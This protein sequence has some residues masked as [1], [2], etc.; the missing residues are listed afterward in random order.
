MFDSRFLDGE[1][2]NAETY[3]YDCTIQAIL[4]IDSLMGFNSKVTLYGED[5]NAYIH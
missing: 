5:Q 4:D 2:T 1:I 3:K